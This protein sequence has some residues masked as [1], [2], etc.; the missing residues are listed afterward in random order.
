M[1]GR[2]RPLP[3]SRRLPTSQTLATL[4]PV[5]RQSVVDAVAD[6][7]RGEILSGRLRPGTRLPS[8]ARAVA[9]PRGEPPDPARVARAARGAGAHHDP[10]RRGHGRRLLARAR[11]ARDA[12]D[13]GHGASSSP[14]PPWH[15]L[16][17]SALELRRILAA[18][19]VALAAE[20]HTDRGPRRDRDVRA[21]AAG[22]RRRPGRLRAGRP[23][24]SCAPSARPRAT[25]ASSSSSTR[26]RAGPTSTRQLVA[27][28]YDDTAT[29]VTIYP[30][31]SRSSSRATPRW[32][33]TLAARARVARRRVGAAPP[34]ARRRPRRAVVA[35]R[36]RPG[37]AA[38]EH[39]EGEEAMNL[40]KLE[41]RW[42]EAAMGAIFPGSQRRPGSPT[43]A[44]WTCAAFLSAGHA[45][46]A[47]PGRARAAAGH[48][49]RRARAA[50]RPRALRDDRRARPGAIASASS[51][52]S[53]RARSTPC[54]RSCSSSRPSARCS[55]RATTRVRARMIARRPPP[56]MTSLVPL[57]RQ[58]RC[59]RR[60]AEHVVMST[61][62]TRS[63]DHAARLPGRGPARGRRRRR[64][65]A[66]R[67]TSTR[68]RLRRRRL[69]R[70][71]RRRGAHAGQGRLLGR[72][73][74]GGAVGED[75][76]VRR[77]RARAP[78]ARMYRDSGTQ[79]LEGA[80]HAAHPGALRRRQH[81][82]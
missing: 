72:D 49:A 48:L 38:Q 64:R 39:E 18:E 19:A 82:S 79:V 41:T 68:L 58:A 45:T 54:G 26:S 6:R 32:R 27:V 17:R 69:G 12:R 33:A 61:I 9:G 76:R 23:R 1:S 78:S 43:S 8:R 7:L 36:R 50:L 44:R 4:A 55:T 13:A 65:G 37:Q 3:R 63:S 2:P 10:P 11:R 71:G 46:R 56:P 73:R 29:S 62:T 52:R 80:L 16:V 42:A 74:R 14:I 81:A 77:A 57:A 40:T 31:S 15:E 59:R 25:S 70:G 75:A 60:G 34:V 30:P 20:R 47:V 51:P 35:S 22:A 67:A 21:G 24:A 53:A 28:L 5:A 66:R